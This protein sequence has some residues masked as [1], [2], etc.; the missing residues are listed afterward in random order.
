MSVFVS[1]PSLNL[2]KCD[3][4]LNIDEV[5]LRSFISLTTIKTH[6]S[7]CD[8]RTWKV[9][10]KRTFWTANWSSTGINEVSRNSLVAP[11]STVHQIV[12]AVRQIQQIYNDF[13]L[14]SSS[15]PCSIRFL[16]Q[17]L[18]IEIETGKCYKIT[19]LLIDIS[20]PIFPSYIA[21]FV[22]TKYFTMKSRIEEQ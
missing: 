10:K 2:Y 5:F 20:P 16:L 19:R 22:V 1:V 18:S 3:W 17:C 14:V 15:Q 21:F 13:D 7:C 12:Y 8:Y 4:S 11:L 6:L 9:T